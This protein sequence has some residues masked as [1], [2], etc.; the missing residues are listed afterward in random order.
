MGRG[1]TLA[2]A[3]VILAYAALASGVAVL[4]PPWE[5]NDETYHVLNVQTIASGRMYRM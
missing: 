3:A 1:P 4:T 2:L 5:A